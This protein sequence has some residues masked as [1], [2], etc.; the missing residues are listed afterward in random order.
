VTRTRAYIVI[1]NDRGQPG[2]IVRDIRE[3]G[4]HR[5]EAVGGAWPRVVLDVTV[6]TQ[7]HHLAK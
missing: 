2:G 3:V 7:R 1:P 4:R 5:P 6:D